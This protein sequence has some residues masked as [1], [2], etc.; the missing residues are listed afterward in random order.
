MAIYDKNNI[1]F[2]DISL[3]SLDIKIKVCTI[4]NIQKVKKFPSTISMITHLVKQI[5]LKNINYSL[6]RS[7]KQYNCRGF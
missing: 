7:R 1:L 4:K 2:K 5:I 3:S 6:V